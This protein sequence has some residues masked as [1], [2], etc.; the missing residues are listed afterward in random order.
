MSA[1]AFVDLL[2]ERQIVAAGTIAQLRKQIEAAAKPIPAAAVAKALLDK[3]L[4]TAHQAQTLL[5]AVQA[6]PGIAPVNKPATPSKPA[7][8]AAPSLAEEFSVAP[9][10][11]EKPAPKDPPKK[12]PA[13]SATPKPAGSKSNLP[14][15]KPVR[16]KP[17]PAPVSSTDDPLFGGGVDDLF[18]S[19]ALSA[20]LN[21][22]GFDPND[23]LAGV[24][25][26][27]GAA[28]APTLQAATAKKSSS[29]KP[30]QFWGAIAGSLLFL[31]AVAGI[32]ATRDNGDAAWAKVQ[33]TIKQSPADSEAVLNGFL[34][35][36]PQHAQA[37]QAQV[38]LAQLRFK[39]LDNRSG[40]IR[41]NA[42]ALAEVVQ[43]LVTEP[44]LKIVH[45]E[46]AKQLPEM[47]RTLLTSAAALD[48]KN[49]A[50]RAE[51]AALAKQLW[52]IGNDPRV[53]P[54]E[55]RPWRSWDEYQETIAQLLRDAQRAEY[56]RELEPALSNTDAAALKTKLLESLKQYPELA[57]APEW[58][59]A[60]KRAGL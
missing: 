8:A 3:Q 41:V 20:D 2:A 19:G 13:T 4:L 21:G 55:A 30:W 58:Q 27:A 5:D 49:T 26:L 10:E 42:K 52:T 38:L 60:A 54:Y 7:P 12:T 48:P 1:K 37:G 15:P 47:I 33:D 51:L 45:P 44:E 56:L 9:Y 40:N 24:D 29:G 16:E 31:G 6:P 28:A 22:G 36:Y 57:E 43:P 46:L 34:A 17:A 53:I 14:P 32:A 23:P 39:Q 25:P 59:T 18:G 11:D 50:G 35:A